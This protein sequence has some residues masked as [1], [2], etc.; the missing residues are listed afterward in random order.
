MRKVF[1]FVNVDWFFY[2]HRMSIAKASRDHNID[3]FV[4]TDFTAKE[5]KENHNEYSLIQSPL[6][7]SSKNLWFLF[8]EF[9]NS[10]LLIYREKPDLI[11]AVTI[12]PIIF[13]GL[14]A[15]LTKTPFIA[16][17]S[18][19]GPVI[20]QNNWFQ[21][22]RF[23]VVLTLYRFIFSSKTVT[24]ICQSENDKNILLKYNI[25]SASK[26]LMISGSGVDLKKFQPKTSQ[27]DHLIVLMASRILKDKGIVEYCTAA[28]LFKKKDKR[29]VKF[30]LA[31]PID[32]VSPS[33]ISEDEIKKLCLDSN[34]EYLGDKDDLEDLLSS[35]SI[36]ILPSYYPEG[37]PKVL[38]EA[39]AC[40]IP[41]IT[42]DH[43][44]CRDAVID[45]K[46]GILVKTRDPDALVDAIKY[47]FDNSEIM[48]EMGKAGR[49][50]AE[51][52][53]N[54]DDVINLHYELYK[55]LT[56]KKF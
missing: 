12:K 39:S 40:G 43:P 20:N 23:K 44:G 52:L 54:E 5:R 46:T 8:F 10:F 13:M 14:I 9:I 55:D 53:Y 6:S 16:A 29:K 27:K 4:Y 25:C 51:N 2:S 26:I 30:M 15:K 18:G 41:I 45:Q 42:T 11:H 17:I 24:T 1:M 3:M 50:L 56:K 34:V 28:K 48:E 35:S 33:S 47:M 31:G 38:L 37:L 49:E 7:R 21:W 22:L 36:F 19:F 32:E